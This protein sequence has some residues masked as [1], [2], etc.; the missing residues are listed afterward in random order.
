[1]IMA[2]YQGAHL[3]GPALDS[4]A[5]Q[6]LPPHEV[7]ICDDGSTDDLRAAIAPHAGSIRL[8]RA[9]H[10]GEGAALRRAAEATTGEYLVQLD[11]DDTYAPGR[12]EALAQAA[13]MR[14]DLD[15]IATDGY[16]VRDGRVLRRYYEGSLSFPVEDQRR[17]VMRANFLL[18]P[19]IRREALEAAGGFDPEMS[20]VADWECCLRLILAGGRAGAV[21]RPL[22]NYVIRSGSMQSDR[23]A[24][25]E[26]RLR[27]LTKA[28]RLPWCSDD[29]RREIDELIE[30]EERQLLL[31]R[32][33]AALVERADGA[34]ARRV[35]RDRR[36]PLVTRAKATAC[37]LAPRLAGAYL[38]SRA[39]RGRSTR[40]V[41]PLD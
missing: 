41:W 18:Q 17:A 26:G 15:L 3:I 13:A 25:A 2:V 4:L 22:Y 37:A 40:L 5:A 14:P 21:M 27:V 29:E 34:P 24:I 30:A 39:R 10:G 12:I 19:A 11:A 33:E 7:V 6:T 8:L 1:M 35:A 28:R 31:V 38:S 36:F 9:P 20:A 32:A 16:L 23:V